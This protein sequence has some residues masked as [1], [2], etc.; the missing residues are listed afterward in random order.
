MCSRATLTILSARLRNQISRYRAAP[1][2]GQDLFLRL[3]ELDRLCRLG[4]HVCAL[5]PLDGRRPF[6][7][8]RQT[9]RLGPM[10]AQNTQAPIV[11][12]R[13]SLQNN[14]FRAWRPSYGLVD[15]CSICRCALIGQATRWLG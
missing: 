9:V 4:V 2:S 6:C 3:C 10:F 11:P 13:L 14:S 8:E 12:P 7:D 1:N 5:R 15:K